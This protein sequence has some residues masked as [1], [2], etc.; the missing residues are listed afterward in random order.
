M[1][2]KRGFTTTILHADRLGKPEHGSLHKPIHTSVTYGHE[3][4]QD[5]VDIFQNK[6]KGYA[7]SRQ[8]NPTVTALEHKVTNME[9][10]LSSIA[11]S[12]GMAAISATVMALIK[13]GDHIVASSFLF[14]NSRSIFQTYIDLGLDITFVDATDV[15]N[16]RNEV[17][18]N[19]K[20][21]FVETIANPA[22]QVAD[23][24]GIGEL[25]T[26]KGI[27][28]VV[29]NTMTSPY[30]FNPIDVKASLVINSL[31]KYIGGHG[32]A[33]GGCVT[34]TGLFNWSNY[35]NIFETFKKQVKPETLGLTQIRKK[36][37]RDAGGTLSPEAA[38]TI[39]VGAETLALRLERACNN[40]L[41]LAQYFESH[42]MIKNVFYPGI[43]S[44][45]QHERAGKL[46]KKFGGLM[47]IELDESI[48]CLAF[49]NKLK[50]VVKSSNLGDTRTLAIPVAQT[51]F[52][53]LGADKRAEM[54]IPE[55]MIRLS[56]G[57]EDLE[58]LM[59]DFKEALG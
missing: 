42:P 4:V 15:E 6:K 28:Y 31:T 18:A 27:I 44:H 38:H 16:V 51:I 58:D 47:S 30:L 17:R 55:T 33:L 20:M 2:T 54:G 56:V 1:T 59:A 10:G 53:E 11:F 45:K 52:F 5:L 32:D 40:A 19:T 12:T 46:F 22:T 21:V 34:D 23:L 37:L 35:P 36:G 14:G 29:D 43:K 41:A 50:L 26:Q 24:Q 8:G 39:A 49:L 7:Y 25:C 48:D 3:D 9:K 57:I 13:H